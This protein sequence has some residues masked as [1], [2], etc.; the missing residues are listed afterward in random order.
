MTDPRKWPKNFPS[1]RAIIPSGVSASFVT[2]TI[3]VS[4][5]VYCAGSMT[6]SKTSCGDTPGTKASPAPRIATGRE[7]R[8][9][10]PDVFG[11]KGNRDR[12]DRG[13]RGQLPPDGAHAGAE[14]STPKV[15]R[16]PGNGA[17]PIET[18][19]EGMR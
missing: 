6:K 2:H 13:R 19:G 8:Q 5:F 11:S 7:D 9:L 3:F 16:V 15:P 12:L 10:G 14:S 4:A 1:S 17:A 18:A